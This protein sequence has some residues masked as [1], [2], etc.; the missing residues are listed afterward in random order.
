MDMET[1]KLEEGGMECND[2]QRESAA[3]TESISD[4]ADNAEHV[5]VAEK[6][7]ESPY[8]LPFSHIYPANS[9]EL[10]TFL[11]LNN[12]IGSAI[13]NQPYVFKESGIVGGLLGFFITAVAAWTGLLCLSAAGIQENVLE[14]SGLARRA[15]GKK[16]ETAV[17]YAIVVLTFGSH[18][19]YI[20]IV[21]S[22]LA[23]L[24]GSWGCDSDACNQICITIIA[25]AVFVTPVCLFRHFGHLAVFS[26]Y[27]LVSIAAV[28]LLVF[29]A[30]PIKHAAEDH[31]DH[32][33][34]FNLP[35][36]LASTGSIVFTLECCSANF[37]AIVSTEHKSQN[38]RTWRMVTGSAVFSAAFL[39]ACMGV[40]G[41]MSF[42]AVTEGQI[43]DNFTEHS[44]DAFKV[45][46]VIQ[47]ILYIPQ[48]FVIMRYSLVTAI[49]GTRSEFLPI[50]T[51]VIVTLALQ[52]GSTAIVLLLLALGLES[53]I[54]FSLLLNITGGV[55]GKLLV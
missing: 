34:L 33:R 39:C 22:L 4:E 3:H 31:S 20:L 7:S 35:G 55:G 14:Y 27:S 2:V 52:I 10:S 5:E 13:L 44:Y 18:L 51:H 29:I 47:L 1:C 37:Q 43:L 8:E 28:L 6:L 49:Y 36:M 41:Y 25:V 48:N 30:G 50:T 16:G 19:S 45:M 17:D 23:D 21:G 32:Y 53:G 40:A 15:F 24:L 38:M 42:G 9:A 12:M 26:V 11:L 54:A 46:V